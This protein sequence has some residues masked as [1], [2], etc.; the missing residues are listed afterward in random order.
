VL[1]YAIHR[2]AT[3]SSRLSA[4]FRLA[5]KLSVAVGRA[6]IYVYPYDLSVPSR[7]ILCVFRTNSHAHGAQFIT[8][9]KDLDGEL[10]CYIRDPDGY[11][12]EVGQVK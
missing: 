6:K 3:R 2:Q 4:R 11:L 1:N 10:R 9:P 12:I 7:Q 8:E 5:Y